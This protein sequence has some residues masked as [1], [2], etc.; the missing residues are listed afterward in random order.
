VESSSF[1]AKRG[2][3]ASP[4]KNVDVAID[5]AAMATDGGVL[6]Y[7]VGEDDQERLTDLAPFPLAGAVDRIGQIVST[8][9]AEVPLFDVR[10]YPLADDAT[11]GYLAIVVPQSARAPHQVTIGGN[12]RF[13]GRGVKG[14]RPLPEAEV[15]RL[16]QRRQSWAIDREQLLAD[17]VA[18]SPSAEHPELGCLHAFAKPVAPDRELFEHAARSVGSPQDM[19]ERLIRA[20]NSTTLRAQYGP[21]LER[22]NFFERQG[23]DDWRLANTSEQY[24]DFAD[25]AVLEDAVLLNMRIDG[26]GELFCGRA[27]ARR[28]NGEQAEI[29]EIVIAGN[30]EAFLAA[31]SALYEAASYHGHVDV[32]VALTGLRDA[33]S[34]RRTRS[35][36]GGR[37]TYRADEFVTS[38][39]FS[40]AELASPSAP[41]QSLLRRFFEA[42]TGIDGYN[43]FE[44][45]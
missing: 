26:R 9:I 1:D 8:G 22:A 30:L 43:P 39:R 16:Y 25:P 38:D 13:Y 7:G 27:T 15:A 20:V 3:P 6:L 19:H 21:N 34:E 18:L 2:L 4:K 14:N 29:M 5:V 23:A 10:E 24:E 33:V 28:I 31:M 42:T 44:N 40:A 17:L 12:L 36:G 37:F 41:A 35:W 45:P 11:T 32:G